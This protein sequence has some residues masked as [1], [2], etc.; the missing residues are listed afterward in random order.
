[1]GTNNVSANDTNSPPRNGDAPPFTLTLPEWLAREGIDGGISLDEDAASAAAVA[2]EREHVGRYEVGQEV[3][4][5]GMGAV[6]QVRDTNLRRSI[7]M[8]VMSTP[9]GVSRDRVL[10]FIEEAQVTGQLEHPS[11]VPVHELGIDEENKPFYTMKLVRGVTLRDLLQGLRDSRQEVVSQCTLGHLLN[12]FLKVCDALAFAHEKGVV[13]RDLKPENIMVGDYG[14]V[15]VMDW[16]L[17]KVLRAQVS[18][19]G[20]QVSAPEQETGALASLRAPV[21]ANVGGGST[22][23]PHGALDTDRSPGQDGGLLAGAVE[24]EAR[25]PAAGRGGR[26]ADG[27]SRSQHRVGSGESLDAPRR[28]CGGSAPVAIQ[29]VRTESD[30]DVALTLDGQVMGTPAFMSPEQA[31]GRVDDI[32]ARTDIYALG[33]VLYNILTLRPPVEGDTTEE[34]LA[35][36]TRGE[37]APPSVYYRPARSAEREKAGSPGFSRSGRPLESGTTSP[38]APKSLVSPP[39]LPNARVPPALSAVTMKAL[40]L[41]R[42]DRYRSVSDLQAD[43][44]AYQSGHATEAEQASLLRQLSLLVKRHTA[45]FGLAAAALAVIFAL[46]A[47]YTWKVS[48]EKGRAERNELAARSAESKAESRRLEA[49]KAQKAEAAQRQLAESA[50]AAEQT[51]RKQAEYDAYIGRIA[52]AD[53]KIRDRAYD[54]AGALLDACPERFRHW[55]WNRLRFLCS[56]GDLTLTPGSGAVRYACFSGDGK[57]ILTVFGSKLQTWDATSGEQRQHIDTGTSA[58]DTFL[59]HDGAMAAT[60]HRDGTVCTWDM[61]RQARTSKSIDLPGR[62]DAAQ[63]SADGR[64]VAMRDSDSGVLF[65]CEVATG[66]IIHTF[67][68]SAMQVV[69]MA[70]SPDNRRLVAGGWSIPLG[71][72]VNA[73]LFDLVTGKEV[74]GALRGLPTCYAVAFSPDGGSLATSHSDGSIRIWS[75]SSGKRVFSLTG[76]TGTPQ[77]LCYSSDGSRLLSAGADGLVKLWNMATA[78]EVLCLEGHSQVV[79]SASFSPDGTKIVTASYDGTA[80]VWEVDTRPRMEVL[81]ACRGIANARFS[82]DGRYMLTGGGYG[83]GMIKLWDARTARLVRQF[84]EAEQTSG[85]DFSPDDRHVVSCHVGVVRV[86]GTESGTLLRT[87]EGH[88]ASAYVIS[89]HYSPD[90]ECLVTASQDGTIRIWHAQ[91]G[92]ELRCFSDG[93]ERGSRFRA[94]FAPDGRQIITTAFTGVLA[95]LNADTG[96]K[97]KSIRGVGSSNKFT[98]DFSPQGERMLVL[99]NEIARLLDRNTDEVLLDLR[100]HAGTNLEGAMFSPDGKRIVTCSRDETARIWDAATGRE[101]LVLRGH[102]GWVCQACFSPDGKTVLTAG[103]DGTARLWWT[104]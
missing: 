95:W 10:R 24:A 99:H 88:S 103:A 76:H 57:T 65:V 94:V 77:S 85:V 1:M 20:F 97:T 30:S 40:A 104:E 41:K 92:E 51:L 83:R 44:E 22:P 80:K 16:G 37:I 5:G 69:V 17:A 8:K 50:R 79:Y 12:I 4:H 82:H 55:E 56:S 66:Q 61:A 18:G 32:D 26:G 3:G 7:A 15:L 43:V 25:G 23:R 78:A 67:Q 29:S 71:A 98:C 28:G 63:F 91:S 90:G 58:C 6:L 46:V 13:H 60:V 75:L 34:I 81:E 42:E 33:A 35:K 89:A 96:E 64:F 52:M 93:I 38:A 48:V 14:E 84:G 11:I 47:G 19:V 49:E 54:Q 9:H 53:Q 87:L 27:A 2:L 45:E 102:K 36:V 21:S 70:F 73:R 74:S 31:E 72:D 100:G 39:H 59:S 68:A 86:W 101:L 62:L